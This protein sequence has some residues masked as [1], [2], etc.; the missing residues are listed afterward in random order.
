[1]NVFCEQTENCTV[2]TI[3]GEI[4]MPETEQLMDFIIDR[5]RKGTH[6]FLLDFNQ[7]PYVDSSG[8]STLLTL[9][10]AARNQGGDI[11]ITGANERINELF[12]QLGLQHMFRLYESKLEGI[13]SFAMI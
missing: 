2:V 5:I 7:V 11:R 12:R 13:E 3:E 10:Q 4:A 6:V 9:L 8:I 1:M